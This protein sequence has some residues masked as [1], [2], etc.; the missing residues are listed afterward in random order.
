MSNWSWVQVMALSKLTVWYN[1]KC[2]VCDAGI[3]RH[4]RRLARAAR[5]GAVEFLQH[6]SCARGALFSR[7]DRGSRAVRRLHGIDGEG[8]RYL[9]ADCAVQIRRRVPGDEWIARLL[10]AA[11]V[12][13]AVN[14][15]Y[16]RFADLLYRY[17]SSPPHC[18]SMAATSSTWPAPSSTPQRSRSGLST[19][20]GPKQRF[21]TKLMQGQT[22]VEIGLAR[23]AAKQSFVADR[24]WPGSDVREG[25]LP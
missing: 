10:G 21:S 11:P 22:R 12:R 7:R 19:S 16:D 4:R 24:Y 13:P 15:S 18:R 5:D 2:P 8:R 20:N 3:A 23:N 25:P 1:T 17:E 14:R 9:G 6:Q